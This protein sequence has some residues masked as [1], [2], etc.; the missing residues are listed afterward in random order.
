MQI[1][2]YDFPIVKFRFSGKNKLTKK[3][4]KR[5]VQRPLFCSPEYLKDILMVY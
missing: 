4:A 1:R 2:V 5:N 3:A